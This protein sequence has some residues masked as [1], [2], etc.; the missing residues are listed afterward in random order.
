MSH[1]K[2]VSQDLGLAPSP[3]LLPE[4]SILTAVLTEHVTAPMLPLDDALTT[5]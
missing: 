3:Q 2:H 5:A 1:R 4:G